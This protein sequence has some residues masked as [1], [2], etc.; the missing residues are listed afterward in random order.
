MYLHSGKPKNIFGIGSSRQRGYVRRLQKKHG[1]CNKCSGGRIWHN[2]KLY[3]SAGSMTSLH[4][5]SVEFGNVKVT[6][7][8]L[9]DITS[10][11]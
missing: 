5:L 1:L 7:Q 8:E 10:L 2:I 4:C 3:F 6:L 9:F 11:W